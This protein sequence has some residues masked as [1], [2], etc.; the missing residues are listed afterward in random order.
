MSF[1]GGLVLKLTVYLLLGGLLAALYLHGINGKGFWEDEIYT[2]RD[3]GIASQDDHQPDFRLSFTELTYRNDNHPPLYFWVI[4][5]WSAVFGFNE[6]SARGFSLLWLLLTLV[7][8][9]RMAAVCMKDF[10]RAGFWTVVVFGTSSTLF[11]LAREARMYTMALFFVAA[12]LSL[13]V[14]LI[15]KESSGKG[16]LLVLS[17][18]L[19]LYTHYYVAF[20]YAAELAVVFWLMLMRRLSRKLFAAL[21]VP[22]ILFAA[23]VPQLMRQRERKYE[24]GLWIIGPKDQTSFLGTLY[25]DGVATLSRLFFGSTFELPKVALIVLLGLICYWLVGRAFRRS[26]VTARVLVALSLVAYILLVGND[27]FH[28]TLTLTRTKYLF[29]LIPPLLLLYVRLSLANLPVVKVV[30]L[31]LIVVFNLAGIARDRYLEQH[32]DWRAISREAERSVGSLP[33]I[34]PDDDYFLC[35]SYYYKDRERI[36]IEDWV[37]VYPEDF[38]YLVLYKQWN[39]GTQKRVGELEQRFEEVNRVEVDRFT[40]LVRYR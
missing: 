27:L 35:M 12:S 15:R 20:F 18:T 4:A 19:G 2:A 32:P 37:T 40:T 7:V 31:V 10:P 25:D 36:Q 38:W 39:P 30:L 11:V 17:S 5:K 23:W 1:P 6:L 21:L 16:L 24:S 29:F 3:I 13:L 9:A 22:G 8:V 34:V 28:H 33:L 14:S 26:D